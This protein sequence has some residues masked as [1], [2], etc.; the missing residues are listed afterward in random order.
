MT[1]TALAAANRALRL[2]P[3]RE[4]ALPAPIFLAFALLP[5]FASLIAKQYLLGGPRHRFR[6]RP[7]SR[8]SWFLKSE[9]RR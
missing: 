8:P 2:R 1:G 5:L 6:A 3:S 9:M 4:V 7:P